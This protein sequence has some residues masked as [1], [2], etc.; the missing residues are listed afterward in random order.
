MAVINST[1]FTRRRRQRSSPLSFSAHTTVAALLA[2]VIAQLCGI[3]HPWWSAMTVWLVAQPTRGL[4][5]ERCIARFAGT[6]V[7]A[8]VG[9]GLLL[10]L[11][12]SPAQLLVWLAAWVALCAGLGN[13]FRHFRNY[14]WVLAGYTAAIVALFGLVDPVLDTQLA[15]GRVVCTLIGILCSTL[16]SWLFTPPSNTSSQLDERLQSVL[17]QSLLWCIQAL[18][19]GDTGQGHTDLSSIFAQMAALDP[20]CDQVAAGSGRGRRD[21]QRIRR[22]LSALIDLMAQ[23]H[24]NNP[25]GLVL[26]DHRASPLPGEIEAAKGQL[27]ELIMVLESQPELQARYLHFVAELKTLASATGHPISPWRQWVAKTVNH[28]WRAA[29]TSAAR[30]LL[31]MSLTTAI[32]LLSSWHDGPMM[33]MTAV[34]FASLFS[35]HDQGNAALVDVLAGSMTG[36]ITGLLCRLWL[37]PM[38]DSTLHMVLVIAPCLTVG[39]FLM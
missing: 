39:A 8:L 37:L 16:T 34:L 10:M 19:Q 6:T 21:A 36:A 26:Q 30:P 32:W 15:W 2:L 5:V 7:G 22:T 35:S 17:N 13:L 27:D 9:G 14:G 1:I 3:H 29:A 33:V 12:S 11:F 24:A 31:A 18:A 23:V 20:L 4:F 25:V 28:D 38:V